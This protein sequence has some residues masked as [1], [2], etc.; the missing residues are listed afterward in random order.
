MDRESDQL[1]FGMVEI[2]RILVELDEVLQRFLERIVRLDDKVH[3][4][5][6][7]P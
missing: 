2:V 1:F 4:V 7:P 6:P 3:G 5:S